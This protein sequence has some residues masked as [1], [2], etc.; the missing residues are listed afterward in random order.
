MFIHYRNFVCTFSIFIDDVKI[1]NTNLRSFTFVLSL[2]RKQGRFNHAREGEARQEGERREE[3]SRVREQGVFQ[4]P[5][6]I[7][8]SYAM[9]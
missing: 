4:P 6:I 8:Q 3:Q 9:Y 5:A 7:A 2:G 1:A